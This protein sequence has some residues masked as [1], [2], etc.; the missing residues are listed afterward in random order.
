MPIL[1]Q[2]TK[3]QALDL[4]A[5]APMRDFD[6]QDWEAFAGCEGKN[7]KIGEIE[8]HTVVLDDDR[9]LILEDG[10]EYGGQVFDI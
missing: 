7:P 10:D 9:L 8:G 4:L 1:T 5:R 3:A 2:V 6:K